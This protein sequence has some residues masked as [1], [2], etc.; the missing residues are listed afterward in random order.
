MI[1]EPQTLPLHNDELFEDWMPFVHSRTIR[2]SLYL[3]ALLLPGP[4]SL[5]DQKYI[6]NDIY[7]LQINGIR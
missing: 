1:E 4:H 6:K 2:Q 5:M 3:F 7:P